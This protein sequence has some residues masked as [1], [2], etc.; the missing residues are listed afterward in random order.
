MILLTWKPELLV[1]LFLPALVFLS[2]TLFLFVPVFF[3]IVVFFVPLSFRAGSSPRGICFW[4]VSVS[5]AWGLARGVFGEP[6]VDADVGAF[7]H[8]Y[9]FFRTGGE[10]RALQAFGPH[11]LAAEP[12]T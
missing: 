10:P 11:Y 6:R 9:C 8:G 4:R 2:V 12:Q 3:R 5:V 7:G 1:G